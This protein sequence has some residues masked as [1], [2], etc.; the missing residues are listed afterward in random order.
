M[1]TC[2]EAKQNYVNYAPHLL[3]LKVNINKFTHKLDFDTHI[4]F[5]CYMPNAEEKYEENIDNKYKENALKEQN[6]NKE[7]LNKV[8]KIANDEKIVAII[9]KGVKNKKVNPNPDQEILSFFKEY[10]YYLIKVAPKIILKKLKS[11]NHI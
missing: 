7:K 1:N 10:F 4:S 6:K 11:K 2:V 9:D 5:G 3:L 8:S